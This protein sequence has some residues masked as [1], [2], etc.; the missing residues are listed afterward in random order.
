M[1]QDARAAQ[2][3]QQGGLVP[4]VPPPPIAP[5][6]VQTQ[7]NVT[8][9]DIIPFGRFDWR[10][11]DVQDGKALIITDWVIFGSEFTPSG[12]EVVTWE[13]SDVR[14]GLNSWFLSFFDT[15]EL[16]RIALTYVVNNNNPWDWTW[17]GGHNRTSGGYNTWDRIFLLSIDE[18]LQH[19]GDSG[20]VARGATMGENVRGANAPTWPEWG[21]YSFGIHDQFSDNRIA[22]DDRDWASQWRL[23]SPGSTPYFAAHVRMDGLL[24]LHGW[25]DGGLGVR[26]ALWLYL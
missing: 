13:T 19:F 2:V 20:M 17:G 16:A 15:S 23:R 3:T 12:F 9:G 24:N 7:A 26:P 1:Q 25:H 10:V 22:I 21:I 18:V 4:P 5:A 6:P 11:L 8:V 14:E